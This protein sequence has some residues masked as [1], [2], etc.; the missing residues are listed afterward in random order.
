MRINE[1]LLERVVAL[2]YKTE[3]NDWGMHLPDH[4]TPLVLQKLKLK[5][6]NQGQALGI[7]HLRTKS[8]G[9]W[10]LF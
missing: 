10:F 1:E 6:A 9:V 5:F 8:H 4:A 2:V 7:V 3:I